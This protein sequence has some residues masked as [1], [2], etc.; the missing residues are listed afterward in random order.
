M[1]K[2]DVVF[3]MTNLKEG[4]NVIELR[5]D[6]ILKSLEEPATRAAK[7]IDP[8]INAVTLRRTQD[9]KI[10]FAVD[11]GSFTIGE[12]KTLDAIYHAISEVVGVNI[13]RPCRGPIVRT[14]L[15]LGQPLH[16]ALKRNAALHNHTLSDEV[17]QLLY[18]LLEDDIKS[19]E[20]R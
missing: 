2:S 10:R 17:E 4:V 6:P 19:N 11:G 16:Q 14:H 18:P 9:D 13:G 20:N 8:S 1:G 15:R 3:D 12:K 7:K 5:E